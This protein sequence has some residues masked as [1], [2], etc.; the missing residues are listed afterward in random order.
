M[1]QNTRFF[2]VLALAMVLPAFGQNAWSMGR[3]PASSPAD[4]SPQDPCTVAPEPSN[5]RLRVNL[6]SLTGFSASQREKVKAAAAIVERVLNSAEFRE[7][8][9]NFRYNGQNK[10]VS[11]DLTPA[12][13]YAKIQ[14]AQEYFIQSADGV[15]QMCLNLYTPPFYKK[16]SVVG[17]TYPNDPHVYMNSYYFNSYAPKDVAANMTHEW[18]HKIGFDHDFNANAAR[19]YSVPYALGSLVAELADRVD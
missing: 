9:L 19:P 18:L 12:E 14:A 15:A 2:G 3:G 16:W 1:K 7:R 5:D 13:V 8:V 4:P 11:T 10:F 17:Y 6:A